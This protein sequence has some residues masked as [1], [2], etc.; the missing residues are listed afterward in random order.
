MR[1]RGRRASGNVLDRRGMGRGTVIGGGGGII[2]IVILL[3]VVFM[4]GD[5]SALMQGPGSGPGGG[6]SGV[7]TAPPASDEQAQFVAVVL[8]DTEDVWHRLFQ[9]QGRQYREPQLVLFSGATQSACGYA[10]AAVGPFY[11]PRDGRIYIDLQFMEQ[12]QRQ[13]GAGG[14][15][16]R[17]Y[18]IAHEV[19][20]HV[21][22]L[23]GTLD[24]VHSARARL[25]E[26][27]YN[28]LSVRLE[29]QADYLA[30][31]WAHHAQKTMEPGDLEEA[32]RAA[33]AVGDDRIQRQTQGQVVPDSFTHGTS[34]QR[35]RW[36]RRGFESG[37]PR[38]GD[39]FATD[40][41]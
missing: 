16:A 6:G 22:N 15:F 14:D 10:Q 40:D 18:I 9:Q 13:L 37:D 31:V 30:G 2:G 5:P 19:G 29:L 7:A 39:T 12:L 1:W 38:K 34:E 4:G 21:Q 11:C 20:H 26:T 8:A 36:F 25:S 32:I 3:I 28:E 41:L 35:I 23:R 24:E 33:G 27:E 17:A